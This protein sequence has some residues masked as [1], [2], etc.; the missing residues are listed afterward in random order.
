MFLITL[1]SEIGGAQI[2]RT[3]LPPKKIS[4]PPYL[5]NICISVFVLFLLLLE[6]FFQYLT[7][8]IVPQ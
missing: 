7:V 5:P 6:T 3:P 1:F 4:T 8:T 2:W